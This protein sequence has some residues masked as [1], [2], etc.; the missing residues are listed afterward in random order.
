MLEK[1]KGHVKELSFKRIVVLGVFMLFIT[2]VAFLSVLVSVG[3]STAMSSLKSDTLANLLKEKNQNLG[4][5]YNDK[6][7]EVCKRDKELGY[8]YLRKKLQ[9]KD[10]GIALYRI[11]MG[12]NFWT[13]A[14]RYGVNIDTIIGANPELEDLKAFKGKELIVLSK[15][16]VIHEVKDKDESLD[17]LAELY[18]T[19][20]EI[21]RKA[22]GIVFGSIKEGE[23]LFIPGAKP[24]YMNENLQKLFAK[25][26]MFRSPI[27]GVYTSLFGTRTHPVTGEVR[28]HNAV[29]IR[30]KI[31]TWVGASAD[32]T[33]VF[34]GWQDNLGYCIKIQHKDGYTSIY[35][36][37]SKIYIR[38]WQKVFAGKLIGK[39]G[40]SGRTTG[41]HLHFAVYK[42]GKAVNPM[43]FLW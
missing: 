31:G 21:I 30:S 18:K 4:E 29:D 10:L 22:N 36:H 3:E 24:V 43:D 38:P 26:S 1:V 23:L 14:K 17:L 32:G 33:V 12:E 7:S 20:K 8:I 6:F 34:A 27:S 16:G 28:G 41:P 2:S 40:N 9:A 39:T 25:R 11:E 5:L 37:L 19:D 35:G 42:N 15:R 13:V